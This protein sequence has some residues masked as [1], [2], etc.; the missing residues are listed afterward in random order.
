[1]GKDA[2]I[3]KWVEDNCFTEDGAFVPDSVAMLMAKASKD[4]GVPVK[5]EDIAMVAMMKGL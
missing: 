5:P 2:D 3:Q 1:M 4:L